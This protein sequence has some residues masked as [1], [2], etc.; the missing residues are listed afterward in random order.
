MSNS[1]P[2]LNV[3][4]NNEIKKELKLISVYEDTTV[5][6]VVTGFIEYGIKIYNEEK[7]LIKDK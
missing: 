7:R 2:L 4:I 1:K 3:R 5:T 6:D